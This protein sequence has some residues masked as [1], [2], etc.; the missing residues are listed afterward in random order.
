MI[1]RE[2]VLRRS[3]MYPGAKKAP[4]PQGLA[5]KVDR[6]LGVKQA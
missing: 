5:C 6:R 1:P 3:R 2:E 4:G